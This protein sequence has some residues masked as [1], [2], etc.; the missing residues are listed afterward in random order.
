MRGRS[1]KASPHSGINTGSDTCPA[2][3]ARPALPHTSDLRTPNCQLGKEVSGFTGDLN[4]QAKEA[5][6][7]VSGAQQRLPDVPGAATF[8]QHPGAPEPWHWGQ[9]T[10]TSWGCAWAPEGEAR[11]LWAQASVQDRHGCYHPS[12][13]QEKCFHGKSLASAPATGWILAMSCEPS[14]TWV[15]SPSGC[16]S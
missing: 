16:T 4:H 10:S 6:S 5:S 15:P 12:C 11:C 8:T 2:V 1:G 3:Q 7:R 13:W 9:A 14:A